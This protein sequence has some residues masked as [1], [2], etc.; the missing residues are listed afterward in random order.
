MIQPVPERR[1]LWSHAADPSERAKKQKA[2]MPKGQLWAS[3]TA[4][5]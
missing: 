1:A 3:K 2:E 5:D 4:K